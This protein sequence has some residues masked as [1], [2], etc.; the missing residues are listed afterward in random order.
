MTGTAVEGTEDISGGM[1]KVVVGRVLTCT[2]VEGT[3]LHECTVDVGGPEPLHIVCGA[4][5]VAAGQLVPVALDGATLP[6]AAG[7]QRAHA[8]G[9]GPARRHGAVS[10][11]VRRAGRHQGKRQP[12]QGK[13]PEGVDMLVHGVKYW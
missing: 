9:G 4:P 6:G 1:E 7:G 11:T 12:G 13:E 3:H 2:D 8:D 10:V 5:N